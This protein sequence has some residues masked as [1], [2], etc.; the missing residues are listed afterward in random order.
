M[1]IYLKS[2]NETALY[3]KN[4]TFLQNML[5][6]QRFSFSK[7]S[8]NVRKLCQINAINVN[9]ENCLCTQWFEISKILA[10]VPKPISVFREVHKR[11]YHSNQSNRKNNQ[12]SISLNVYDATVV[13]ATLSWFWAALT[14]FS[15]QKFV[16]QHS[17]N[18]FDSWGAAY[19]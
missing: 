17:R 4:D 12:P 19:E 14:N 8:W 3:S 11:K 5:F 1:F 18:C 16:F 6:D 10:L 7:T 9:Q 13:M 15:K 2:K